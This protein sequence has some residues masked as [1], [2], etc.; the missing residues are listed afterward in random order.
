M[1]KTTLSAA[2]WDSLLAQTLPSRP[3]QADGRVQVMLLAPK[4]KRRGEC[5]TLNTSES[6]NDVAESSLSQVLERD[7]IPQKYFLSARACQG[8]LRRAENRGKRLPPALMAVLTEQA[9]A[10]R[11]S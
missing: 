11:I 6:P 1:E 7:S 9:K 5:L 3:A 4:E 10:P 8:I 2:S